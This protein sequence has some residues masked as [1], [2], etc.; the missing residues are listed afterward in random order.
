MKNK[1]TIND[2]SL[3]K[4]LEVVDSLPDWADKKDFFWRLYKQFN[5]VNRLRRH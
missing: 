1:K 3:L 5:K 4:L 2:M